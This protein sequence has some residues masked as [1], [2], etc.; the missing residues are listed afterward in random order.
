MRKKISS[1]PGA[2]VARNTNEAMVAPTMGNDRQKSGKNKPNIDK[3]SNILT[4]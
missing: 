4:V 2:F 1:D 3:S